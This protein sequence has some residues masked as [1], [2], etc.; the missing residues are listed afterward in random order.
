MGRRA[1]GGVQGEVPKAQVWRSERWR[2]ALIADLVD[3]VDIAKGGSHGEHGADGREGLVALPNV[4]GLNTEGVSCE[5][6]ERRGNF[7]LPASPIK[8]ECARI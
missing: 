7:F 6:E 8:R 3:T 4:L 1:R 2:G 5:G